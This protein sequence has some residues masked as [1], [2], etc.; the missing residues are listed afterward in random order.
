MAGN[1]EPVTDLQPVDIKLTSEFRDIIKQEAVP[2]FS[3]ANRED[4]KSGCI[5]IFEALNFCF[6]RHSSDLGDSKALTT[7]LIDFLSLNDLENLCK[8]SCLKELSQ[9]NP[10]ITADKILLENN[11][12]PGSTSNDREK[13]IIENANSDHRQFKKI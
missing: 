2:V 9:L 13:E 5:K 1:T 6:S 11:V 4:A 8:S 12:Y 3:N 10:L 7:F